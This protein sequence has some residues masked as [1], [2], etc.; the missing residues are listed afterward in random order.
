MKSQSCYC[1]DNGLTFP[2]V[3]WSSLGESCWTVHYRYTHWILKKRENAF[4][5]TCRLPF[6]LL[7]VIAF[8][9]IE[10]WVFVYRKKDTASYHKL[11]QVRQNHSEKWLE[12]EA[13]GICTSLSSDA[14]YGAWFLK[15]HHVIYFS[16][17]KLFISIIIPAAGWAGRLLS[18]MV[19]QTSLSFPEESAV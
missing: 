17:F 7:V 9:S 16:T 8:R 5:V 15:Q 14:C 2:A 19:L 11:R 12:R 10:Q 13:V 4:T 6:T 18:L 1:F 3:C